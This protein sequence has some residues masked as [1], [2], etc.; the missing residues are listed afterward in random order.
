MERHKLAKP[1]YNERPVL[2][3]TRWNVSWFNSH[4]HKPTVD[5]HPRVGVR[6]TLFFTDVWVDYILIG[7]TT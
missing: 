3:I 7:Q 5:G 6:E 1:K 4:L 2:H